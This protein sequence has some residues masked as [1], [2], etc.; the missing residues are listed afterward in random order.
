M[1]MVSG[2]GF[3][4]SSIVQFN[5]QSRQTTFISA[6]RLQALI[7][8]GDVV[9]GSTF[10]VTVMNPVSGAPNEEDA[11]G[12]TGNSVV[13]TVLNPVPV[14][15]RIGPASAVKGK[16]A[17]TLET[18]GAGFV[19]VSVLKWDGS[20]RTTIV[21]SQNRVRGQI[22]AADTEVEGVGLISITNP[23]PGGGTSPGAFPRD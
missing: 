18:E 7:L 15:E 14:I 11:G 5:G 8:A 22:T 19:T 13:V 6:T 17:L 4:P 1:L 2:T 12:I 23:G 21:L 3:T 20:D 10:S 16:G 9:T